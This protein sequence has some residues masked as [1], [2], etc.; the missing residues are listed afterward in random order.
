M[1]G[2]RNARIE[3]ERRSDATLTGMATT[4]IAKEMARIEIDGEGTT[5]SDESTTRK[6]ETLMTIP[7]EEIESS[8]RRIGE[9]DR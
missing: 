9:S 6:M 2:D 7:G 1:N 5:R 4:I 8:P 3:N